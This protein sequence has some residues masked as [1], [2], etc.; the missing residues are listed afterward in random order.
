VPFREG[1]TH[2]VPGLIWHLGLALGGL[3]LSVSPV[4]AGILDAT[5]TAPT[6]NVD[7]SPLTD[8]AAYRIYSGT[9]PSP[10]PGSSFLEIAASTPSPASNE[11]VRVTLTGLATDTLYY[12]AV[13]AVDMSGNVSDCFTPAQNAVARIDFS[14]SPT[15]TTNFGSTSVGTFVDQIFTVQNTGGATVAGGVSSSAP[16]S[17]VSGGSFNLVGV[18]AVQTVTVRFTPTVS[19]SVSANVNFAANG[20]TISRIVTGSGISTD[21]TPP[22]V[23]ISVPTSG[24]TYST[25]NPALTLG[26]TATDNVAVTQV[27]WTNSRG[28]SGTA[29]GTTTWTASGIVL[30]PGTNALTV[31]AQD[32]AG[33]I[34][35]ASITVSFDAT[36]PVVAVTSPT[37]GSTYSTSN[38]ALTLAGTA[39]DNI[40]VTQVTW[41]NSRGGTGTASGTTSWTAGGIIL[42]PGTNMLTVTARDAAGNIATTTLPVTFSDTTPP[43]VAITSPTAGSTYSTSIS[44]LTLGGTAADDVGVSQVTWANNRGGGGTASGT[45]SWTAS[46]IV[47]QPGTNVLTVTARDGAANIAT[48]SLTVTFNDTTPPTIAITSPTAGSTYSTSISSLTLGGVAADNVAVSQVTWANNRGGSGTASGTTSWTAS[49]IIL[50]PGANVLTVTAWDAASNTAVASLTITVSDT[51]PPTVAITSPTAGSTYST[52]ISSLTLAGTAADDVGVTQV[53][54]TNSRGGS[55]TTSGTTSWMAGGI[56]LQPGTNVL[57]V[58]AQDAAS[59]S[60]TASVTVTLLDTTAPAVSITAPTPGSPV[61]GTITVS[62]SATDN[63]GVV[64]VQFKLDGANLGAEVAAA[65]YSVSWDTTAAAS[66]A[67]N[68]TAVARD[69]SGNTATSTVV[70]VNVSNPVSSVPLLANGSFESFTGNV[71]TGWTVVSDG[72][73]AFTASP[74][75]GQTGLAQQITI[76][77]SGNWGLYLSQQPAF[78]LNQAYALTLW[79]KTSGA[80]SVWVQI[81]DAPMNHVVLSQAL[82]ATS[83]VWRQQTLSFTY[84]DGLADELRVISNAVGSFWLDEFSLRETVPLLA[85][86]SFESFTGNVATGWT[87]VSDGVVAFTASPDTGQTGLA[88][89]ITITRS[90]N[91]GLYLSQQP[92]FKLNQAYALTLWYKTSGANSVWVQITDAPMNHVVLSQALPATGGVWRQQTLSFTYTDGLADELRVI[93]NAVGTF[94]LD[95]FSLRETAR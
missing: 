82:P 61:S 69:A 22:T 11:T 74:D 7:G 91:W 12:V 84:T 32:A 81:T 54:W 63:V 43:T 34:G 3:L 2:R 47:L 24:S 27:T 67:H 51:T 77:R 78:K 46:G 72:V 39:S 55:G 53:T 28:G 58:T 73:V 68:L 44:S 35:T 87:V 29:N 75:T 1:A 13:A 76:T 86:G 37:A 92:A 70:T 8:L 10:C 85:N 90:G 89:Q 25:A 94:W 15:G 50:Q 57:T 88:Q 49:G 71:A 41:T 5:W 33:N 30:Q 17:V 19:A 42:Q 38:S 20:S 62:A 56:T 93:S 66:Q 95:E 52:S 45:M 16:F 79:Y 83:G 26:G 60:A 23:A 31:A 4:R 36:P 14:V 9:S 21:T 64:G 59:N 40:A 18:G 80:N 6:T 65:P 48:A